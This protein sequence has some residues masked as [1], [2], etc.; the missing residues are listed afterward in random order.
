MDIIYLKWYYARFD[1]TPEQYYRLTKIIWT[2][3]Y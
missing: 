2:K 3:K 1:I